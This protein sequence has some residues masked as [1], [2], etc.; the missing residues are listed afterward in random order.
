MTIATAYAEATG[1]LEAI[2]ES[3]L[4]AIWIS[5]HGVATQADLEDEHDYLRHRLNAQRAVAFEATQ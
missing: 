4:R 2:A 5:T 1:A 3:A